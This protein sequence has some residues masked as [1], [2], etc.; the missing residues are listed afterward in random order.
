MPERF[1]IAFLGTG[2]PLP[3]ADRCGAGQ[4]IVAGE[5]NVLVDCGWG[6]AR[7]LIPAGV[8]PNAIDTALFTH[9]H[10]DHMTDVPD[11]LFLRW[12]GGATVPLRVYGPEGTQEMVDGFLMAL[13]RDIGYRLAHHGDKL[14][15]EGIKVTVTELPTTAAPTP[16]LDLGGL[17]L[18]AFEVDHFPVVPAFGYRAGFDG[19]TVVLSGDTKFCETL[20]AASAGAD[21]LICEALNMPMFE[22]RVA[23][24]TAMGMTRQAAL[25]GDVPSYHIGTAEI[26]KLARDANVGEVVLSHIIP[27]ISNDA[28]PVQEFMAGMSDVFGGPIRVARDMERIPVTKRG[29]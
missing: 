15:P 24:I 9:M 19:R 23:A 28:A 6:A 5:T 22:Q 8:R 2:S 3:S 17:R 13:R 26:A 4:V 20:A 21:M 29:A 7:R 16:F 11:F 25:M 27:P 14:H 1:E 18:E 10:T 12:T